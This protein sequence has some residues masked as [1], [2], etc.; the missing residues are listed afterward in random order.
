MPQKQSG[1]KLRRT[2]KHKGKYA[3]Q[4]F[5]TA[6][7]KAAARTRIARRKR[8]NPQPPGRRHKSRRLKRQG[9]AHILTQEQA[10]QRLL[11]GRDI[12]QPN[13]ETLDKTHPQTKE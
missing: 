10:Y 5:R 7:N 8:D 4:V 6:R 13:E 12:E 1:I 2:A 3:A 11:K 9:H